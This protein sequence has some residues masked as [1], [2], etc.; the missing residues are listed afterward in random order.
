MKCHYYHYYCCFCSIDIF[1]A[2]DGA[3]E[4]FES[5]HTTI[6]YCYS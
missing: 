1:A 6:I 3:G 2:F 5:V 4:G